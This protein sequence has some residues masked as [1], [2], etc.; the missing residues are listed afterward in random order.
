MTVSNANNNDDSLIFSG[1][2]S[3]SGENFFATVSTTVGHCLAVSA[4]N[5]SFVAMK[6]FLHSVYTTGHNQKDSK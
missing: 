3:R 6:Y 4:T 1:F 5:F 2:N